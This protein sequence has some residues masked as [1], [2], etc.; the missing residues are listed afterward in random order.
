MLVVFVTLSIQFLSPR[1][2][3]VAMAPNL[4]PVVMFF[5]ILGWSGTPLGLATAMIAAIAIG[6]GV[7]EAVHLLAEFNYHI[8]KDADQPAAVLAAL[9]TIGPPVVYTTAALVV[10][11]LVLLWSNFVP[12]QQ[13]GAFTALSVVVSLLVD[14]LVLPAILVSARF[15]TLWDVRPTPHRRCDRGRRHGATGRRSTLSHHA[16]ATLS[17]HRGD[18]VPQSDPYSQRPTRALEPAAAPDTSRALRVAPRREQRDA[19]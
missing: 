12:L 16:S 11:V 5:G 1:F 17:P 10:G 8:R 15:V 9:R 19:S 6:T 7:D 14:L 3:V 13:F 2:G 18:R 4:I